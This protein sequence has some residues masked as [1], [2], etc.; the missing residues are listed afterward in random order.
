MLSLRLISTHTVIE[1]IYS[2][3]KVGR[4]IHPKFNRGYL[5]LTFG[6]FRDWI[7]FFL[8]F[9]LYSNF[10]IMNMYYF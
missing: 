9:F 7:S 2:E 6:R 10:Y 3:Q 5:L 4:K 8:V 1:I